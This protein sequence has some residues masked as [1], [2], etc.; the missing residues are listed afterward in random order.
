MCTQKALVVVLVALGVVMALVVVVVQVVV[1]AVVVVVLLG[2]VLVVLVVLVAV[3][4]GAVVAVVV[5]AL[6]SSHRVGPP[7]NRKACT[8]RKGSSTR[9]GTERV[10]R[11]FA[12]PSLGTRLG[13]H[14][15]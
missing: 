8:R 9:I 12:A 11:P 2:V 6:A 4:V 15:L 7:R 3:V 5:C 13:M 14:W 10:C 1:V